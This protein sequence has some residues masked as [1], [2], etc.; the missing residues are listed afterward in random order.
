[1]PIPVYG[2]ESGKLVEGLSL[3]KMYFHCG[4]KVRLKKL[5]QAKLLQQ[6]LRKVGNYL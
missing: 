2:G 6:T 4:E 5:L 1:M 3:M